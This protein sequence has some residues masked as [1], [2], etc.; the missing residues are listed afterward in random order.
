MLNL[1]PVNP[2][3]TTAMH[4]FDLGDVE[5][6]DGR[7]HPLTAL[8]PVSLVSSDPV[9]AVGVGQQIAN[10]VTGKASDAVSGIIPK[11]FG[12]RVAVGVLAIGILLI[13]AFRLAK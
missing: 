1:P 10:A 9:G 7:A 12:A 5:S 2:L 11:H 3:D 8:T 4:F 13:V 6:P